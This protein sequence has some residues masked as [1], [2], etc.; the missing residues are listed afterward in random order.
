MYTDEEIEKE[1]YLDESDKKFAGF[2]PLQGN[3]STS[4]NFKV[5][6]NFALTNDPKKQ[7]VLFV[8]CIH[9]YYG[10]RAF[11]M[12]SGQFS[13]HPDEK[14]ILLCEGA[15]VAVMGLEDILIDNDPFLLL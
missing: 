10:Y 7:M 3:T 6:L 9:N 13:T 8:V 12:N 5:A 15:Q 1:D 2:I 14:E 4:E 11:R